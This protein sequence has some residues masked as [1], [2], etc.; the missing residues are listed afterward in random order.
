MHNSSP[1]KEADGSK[2]RRA[3]GLI[4][5]AS[6]CAARTA[7]QSKN[8][9]RTSA[10]RTACQLKRIT[11]Q[12]P[13]GP[14]V[15]QKNVYR[16]SDDRRAGQSKKDYR[17]SAARTSGRA[18]K[19]AEHAPLEQHSAL[20]RLQK[21]RRTHSRSGEKDNRTSAARSADGGKC[22]KRTMGGRSDMK[23]KAMG[24]FVDHPGIFGAKTDVARAPLG[25]P[26]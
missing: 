17:T 7:S 25:V 10:D 5:G 9:Y 21:Q 12:V 19:I 26:P 3:A 4:K 8:D 14:Q 20:K 1:P 11:E 22:D 13:P 24:E 18:K 16:T 2:R 15:S 6:G 23:S